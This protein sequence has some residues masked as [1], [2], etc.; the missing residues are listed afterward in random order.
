[1]ERNTILEFL[2]KINKQVLKDI[3]CGDASDTLHYAS[4]V[5]KVYA[6]DYSNSMLAKATTTLKNI[7]N[8]TLNKLDILKDDLLI[9]SDIVITKRMLINLGSFENQ[10]N[11]IKKIYESLN[12]DGYFIMLETSKNGLD[13]LNELRILFNLENIPEPFHNTMFELKELKS[14]LEN[15]FVIEKI[16][17]FSTYY[18]LTRVYNVMVDDVNYIK[19]D[20]KARQISESNI[21]LFNSKIIGPQF[22]MLLKKKDFDI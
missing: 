1:M 10:K 8:V 5:E 12:K 11:A 21:D 2:T 15:Y 18:F 13:N 4:L 3:G 7:S 14:F 6:Y 19:L 22:C 16:N 17:Y 9:K 20:E